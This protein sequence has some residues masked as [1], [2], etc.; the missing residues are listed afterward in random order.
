MEKQ[1]KEFSD[2][3]ELKQANFQEL[4]TIQR[5]IIQKEAE[6]D[7][8]QTEKKSIAQKLISYLEKS[9]YKGIRQDKIIAYLQS[10]TRGVPSFWEVYNK[11][12]SELCNEDKAKLTNTYTDLSASKEKVTG[13]VVRGVA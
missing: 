3:T 12:F 1:Y 6:L 9:D 8:L 7:N 13:L 2:L 11:I 4:I 10:F 5:A